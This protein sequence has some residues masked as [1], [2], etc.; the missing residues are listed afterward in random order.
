M[1]LIPGLPD[2]HFGFG[3]FDE[4]ALELAERGM[5]IYLGLGP[6]HA[7]SL[8]FG[9]SPLHHGTLATVVMPA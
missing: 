5:S 2:V 1:A 8:A 4:L 3:A 9:D 6:I 7:L